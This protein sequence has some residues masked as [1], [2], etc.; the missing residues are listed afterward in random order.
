MSRILLK[1]VL[2]VSMLLGVA[3]CQNYFVNPSAIPTG[4]KYHNQKYKTIPSPEPADLGYEY[5]V[6]QNDE[7]LRSMRVK[8]SQLLDQLEAEND[9]AN[10]TV[11]VFTPHDHNAQNAAFDNVLRDELRA[12][13]YYLSGDPNDGYK[14]GYSIREPE[15]L[16]HHVDF[17]HFNGDEREAHHRDRYHEYEQMIVELALMDGPDTL[18]VVR[19][20]YNMPM[21][22]YNRDQYFHVLKPQVGT[23]KKGKYILDDE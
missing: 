10:K 22:G 20:V 13:D 2:P 17:G 1:T 3:A 18:D 11:Y 21:Y 8:I 14:L 12:R 4:Y 19:G 16:E 5:T 6:E 15:D 7:I 9:L 23:P